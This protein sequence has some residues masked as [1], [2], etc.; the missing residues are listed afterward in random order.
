MSDLQCAA[1]LLFVQVVEGQGEV[2]SF[3]EQVAGRR[4]VA[5]YSSRMEP[6]VQL[7]ELASSRLGLQPVFVDG[8]E[9]VSVDVGGPGADDL[10]VT[11]FTEAIEGIADVHRGETVLVF[12]HGEVMA[13]AI[14]L[15]GQGL[16]PKG[17][18]LQVEVD[19][20]GWRLDQRT[21]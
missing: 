13:L 6:A 12:T 5:V 10:Q 18:V 3:L 14:P 21:T 19:G 15:V 7:A 17:D 4:V 20:D 16:L 8:L 9:E 2:P 11:A 1:T